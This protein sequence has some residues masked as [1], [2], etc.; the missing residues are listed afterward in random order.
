MSKTQELTVAKLAKQIGHK[1]LWTIKSVNIEVIIQDITVQFG[2]AYFKI[3]PV[4]GSGLT[5][6]TK[7]IKLLTPIFGDNAKKDEPQIH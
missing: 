4:A 6:V 7:G 2:K 5:T 1:A 3:S